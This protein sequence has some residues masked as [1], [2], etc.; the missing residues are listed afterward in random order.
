MCLFS[1]NFSEVQENFTGDLSDNNSDHLLDAYYDKKC[2]RRLKFSS[3]RN[4]WYLIIARKHKYLPWSIQT[5]CCIQISCRAILNL[6]KREK[7]KTSS[8]HIDYLKGTNFCGS[9]FWDFLRTSHS[10]EPF[11]ELFHLCCSHLKKILREFNFAVWAQ[12]RKH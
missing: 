2:Q 7:E 8:H 6:E 4:K 5:S 12:I 10:F 1:I 9:Q 3:N 11:C